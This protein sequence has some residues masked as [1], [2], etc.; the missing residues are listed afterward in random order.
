MSVEPI[1]DPFSIP[2]EFNDFIGIW[3]NFVSPILCDKIIEVF[4]AGLNNSSIMYGEGHHQFENRTGKLGR[5]DLSMLLNHVDH[6]LT[7][8]INQYLHTCFL[9]YVDEY[10][11]LSIV[12]LMSTNVK[13]QKTS[14]NGGYH[15]W[16]YENSGYHVSDRELTWMIYLNDMPEGEAETEFM[17]QKL[18]IS[19]SKGTLLIWPAGMTHVHRGLTVYSQDKYIATGWFNKLP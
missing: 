15:T 8:H 7:N 12:N 11:Q 3:K 1:V 6:E 2:C 10:N 5:N 14:P 16:H 9:R 4:D 17:Y 18:R 19:P 13:I